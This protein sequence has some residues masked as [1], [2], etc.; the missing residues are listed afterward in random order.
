A[1]V[2]PTYLCSI[3]CGLI[4]KDYLAF[5]VVNI[6]SPGG[7]RWQLYVHAYHILVLLVSY[8]Q[9]FGQ[10]MKGR[11]M[12]D[13]L[14]ACFRKGL[15]SKW[16]NLT[17]PCI[18]ALRLCCLEMQQPI[19]RMLP[20]ILNDLN[21]ISSKSSLAIPILELLSGLIRIPKLYA[22]FTEDHYK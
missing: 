15:V 22:N 19:T 17:R 7:S 20:H 11:A 21:K 5:H 9:T 18:Y 13:D 6:P 14:L 8:Q 2:D 3:L 1:E 4:K 16:R 10:A 12:K